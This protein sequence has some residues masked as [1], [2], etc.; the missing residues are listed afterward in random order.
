MLLAAGIPF[1]GLGQEAPSTPD[2]AYYNSY[3]ERL[4]S[5]V[6]AMRRVVVT[7]T[8]AGGMV[9]RIYD[10]EGHCLEQIPYADKAGKVRDGLALKWFASGEV[11]GRRLYRDGQLNGQLQLYYLDGTVQMLEFYEKGVSKSRLCFEPNGQPS[12]CPRDKTGSRTYASYR[13]GE[14]V[15]SKEVGRA[16]QLL[17]LPLP[18]G[19]KGE[20][21]IVACMVGIDGQIHET[22]VYKSVG[23]QYDREAL[24]VVSN[25]RSDWFPELESNEPIESFYMVNVDFIPEP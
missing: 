7:P 20:R 2:T 18:P 4:S 16:V 23:P 25:L 13:K 12:E 22:Q 1:V 9:H 11:K 10:L 3:G 17:Q 14:S 15:L 19:S 21:V 5:R 24:R 8:P 6:G